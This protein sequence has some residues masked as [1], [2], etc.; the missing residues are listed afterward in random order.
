ML[1]A[2]DELTVTEAYLCD[3]VDIEG[4]IGA[5][6]EMAERL[7]A[8]PTGLATRLRFARALLRLPAAG[9]RSSDGYRGARL[10]GG[11]HSKARDRDAIAY[12]YDVSNDFF[13]LW[14]D[15]RMLYSCAYFRTGDED[16]DEAQENKLDQ[17]CRK[18]RLRRGE[19]LLDIG[20]G[21]GGL[22]VHAGLRYGAEAVGITLSRP[23]AQLANARIEQAGLA[24]RCRVEYRDYRDL[25]GEAVYDKVA[26]IG[27]FEHVGEAM[28]P[29]YF[30]RALT[31]LRPGGVFL[32]HGI[33]FARPQPVRRGPTFFDRYVFPD[34]ELVALS[35]TLRAA[36]TC[37]FEVRD[38][39]S[40]REHYEKTLR[41]WITRLEERRD[42]ARRLT[43][44]VTY[45]VWRLYMALAAQQFA[46]GRTTLYQTLLCKP[47][48]G[49]SG[50]PLTRSDWYA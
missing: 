30:R 49:V 34:G 31:L 4:D 3:D 6:V 20:C 42:D 12:H 16:L 19:R 41:H 10:R 24:G 35:D 33:A 40:L 47:A 8:Q 28:L 15:H 23:Q 1:W 37:G 43:N 13:A 46:T 29:E 17:I 32:N 48:A 38:V 21:W 45:R 11:L 2:A 18:L 36:E 26:S 39:E 9:R 27:M 7:L 14:L 44:E 22:V 25:T 50:F 5:L